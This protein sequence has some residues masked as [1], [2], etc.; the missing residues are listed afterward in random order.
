MGGKRFE[1]EVTGDAPLKNPQAYRVVGT[2][3]PRV[4]IPN[5]LTGQPSF[6]Q[7]LRL[8]G[9][10][11]GRVVRPPSVGAQL[12]ALD[13]SS[14]HDL[15]RAV[16]VVR[17]GNFVGVVAE[18][19][20]QAMRAAQQLKVEWRETAVLPRMDDLYS[21]LRAQATTDNVLAGSGDID[22]AMQHA[23]QQLHATY[24]QPYHAHASIAPA[25][26]VADVR[27]DQITV[28]A[29]TQGPYPLRGALA[30]LLAVPVEQV[31][32]IHV[33]SAGCYG[34]NGADDAAA[35]A[36]LL[37]RAAGKPVRVQWSRADEFVWEPKAAAMV[38]EVRGGIDAQGHVVAWDYHV[39]SPNHGARPRTC[40]RA[41]VGPDDP[42]RR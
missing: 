18:R 13:E 4:D 38:M 14:L 22:G 12:I 7:D 19:E 39:W 6:V 35:D 25:C 24:Y 1:R 36:L 17:L 10:L 11:H 30:Q 28:W 23:S 41:R 37:A 16:Q 42:R 26:A 21:V 8:A 3:V 40:R 9:M 20:E 32:L 2:S 5:K 27:A 33:E 34:Q 31:R 15:P 29:S